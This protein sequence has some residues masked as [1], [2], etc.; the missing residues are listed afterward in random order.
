MKHMLKLKI[1]T[2]ILYK[3]QLQSVPQRAYIPLIKPKGTPKATP[4][5]L[6]TITYM[7]QFETLEM[8]HS[9][10]FC[11]ILHIQLFLN[12]NIYFLGALLPAPGLSAALR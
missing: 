9:R 3:V 6:H 10:H 8:R 1:V 11:V 5:H 7:C 4:K 2:L 12:F